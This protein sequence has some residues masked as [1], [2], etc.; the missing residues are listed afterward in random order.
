VT[1]FIGLAAAFFTTVSYFPQV[2]K[3]WRTGETDDLSL[4]M[5]LALLAGLALWIV[6]GILQGDMVIVLANATSFCLVGIV[7]GFKIREMRR[8]G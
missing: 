2:T 5:L 3:V 7:A 4:K 1:T 8:A 6:Y